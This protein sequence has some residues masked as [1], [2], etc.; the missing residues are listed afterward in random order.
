MILM[1]NHGHNQMASG[2]A[3]ITYP[4]PRASF[5]YRQSNQLEHRRAFMCARIFS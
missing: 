4:H 2:L 1:T 5:C 3:A